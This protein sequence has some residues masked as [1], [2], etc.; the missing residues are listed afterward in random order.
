M[1]PN[2]QAFANV[3]KISDTSMSTR[4][5][6]SMSKQ[7]SDKSA[8]LIVVAEREIQAGLNLKISSSI[9]KNSDNT[10]H[11]SKKSNLELKEICNK[12]ANED[13]NSNISTKIIKI[14][15]YEEDAKM[16]ES[17][18]DK[19]EEFITRRNISLN[20]N[21]I[22]FEINFEKWCQ[23]TFNKNL[24]EFKADSEKERE[25]EKEL[26]K[27]GNIDQLYDYINSNDAKNSEK[28]KNK[29]KK[30]NKNKASKDP[31]NV[32][33]NSNNVNKDLNDKLKCEENKE[34]NCFEKY[35]SNKKP[36]NAKD[37]YDFSKIYDA[38]VEIFKQNIVKDNKKAS[39]IIKIKPI[40]SA[41]WLQTLN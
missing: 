9:Y 40:F 19:L 6:E 5:S 7:A 31:N 35:N 32:A 12:N 34:N 29:R 10:E 36:N 11:L 16:A 1:D 3:S 20:E 38:E 23:K 33:Y 22:S 15:S 14:T 39:D 17:L 28:K 25:R 18:T 24:E 21:S 13:D 26:L 37:K 30:K 2:N 41:N 4:D 27:H 8:A